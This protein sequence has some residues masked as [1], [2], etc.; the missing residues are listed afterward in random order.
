[1]SNILGRVYN[2]LLINYNL[3]EFIMK[4]FRILYPVAE[5]RRVFIGI[6]LD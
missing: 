6:T 2:Y 1:M 3:K 4:F 5:F